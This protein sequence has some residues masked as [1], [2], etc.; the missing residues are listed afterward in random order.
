MEFTRQAVVAAMEAAGAPKDAVEK[1][2]P[3]RTHLR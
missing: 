2:R 3:P 1:V